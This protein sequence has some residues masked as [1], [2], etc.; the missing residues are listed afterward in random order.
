MLREEILTMRGKVTLKEVIELFNK[1]NEL[2]LLDIQKHFNFY[3]SVPK[4]KRFM[5]ILKEK[6]L[7]EIEKKACLEGKLQKK[8]IFKKV[9]S[10]ELQ[11]I[12]IKPIV[13]AEYD[14]VLVT[15]DN[16]D[17]VKKLIQDKIKNDSEYQYLSITDINQYL[18]TPDINNKS[19]WINS[20]GYEDSLEVRIGDYVV[21]DKDCRTYD[22]V[23][24]PLC[25]YDKKNFEQDFEV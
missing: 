4:I 8:I 19:F 24:F 11:K 18:S 6:G 5:D 3:I 7:I 20:Y 1:K 15:E 12:K 9:G 10:M 13:Q 2:S 16:I 21:F 25:V 22:G 17:D 14:Y 23:E